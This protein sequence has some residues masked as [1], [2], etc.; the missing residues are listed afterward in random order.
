M[1][2]GI[3]ARRYAFGP[4]GYRGTDA[5]HALFAVLRLHGQL[6][7]L[8]L[9]VCRGCTESYLVILVVILVVIVVLIILI[10]FF[11]YAFDGRGLAW[12]GVSADGSEDS[13]VVL[14]YDCIG[15]LVKGRDYSRSRQNMGVCD[16]GPAGNLVVA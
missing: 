4:Q 14:G 9:L 6:S 2:I 16:F 7:L 15:G 10:L 8:Q 12:A 5:Y 11:A 3:W 13:R 1:E